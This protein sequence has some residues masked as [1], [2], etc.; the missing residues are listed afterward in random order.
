[1]SVE[2]PRAGSPA[3]LDRRVERLEVAQS[4]MAKAIDRVEREQKHSHEIAELRFKG[5]EASIGGL[6]RKLDTIGAAFQA[7]VLDSTKMLGD[8]SATPAGRQIMA[9]I[10][11]LAEGRDENRAAIKAMERRYWIATGVTIGSIIA[12]PALHDILVA[13]LAAFQH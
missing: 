11:E 9:D 7:A 12:A 10:A 13:L 5:L 8:P 2:E 6:D 4:E 1:M 3:A